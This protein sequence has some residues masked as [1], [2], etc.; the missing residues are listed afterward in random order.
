MA[1]NMQ[2]GPT[3]M[4]KWAVRYHHFEQKHSN[5]FAAQSTVALI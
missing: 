2:F 1:M 5:Q 4:H 3:S